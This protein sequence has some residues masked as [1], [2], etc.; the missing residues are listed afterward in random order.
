MTIIKGFTHPYPSRQLYPRGKIQC[1]LYYHPASVRFRP[2]PFPSKYSLMEIFQV[3]YLGVCSFG[4]HCIFFYYYSL[5]SLFG[6]YLNR[7]SILSQSFSLGLSLLFLK[8]THLLSLGCCLP[9]ALFFLFLFFL[10]S[11]R[12][13][14]NCYL[15]LSFSG[16][17]LSTFYATP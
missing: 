13:K 17:K 16:Y 15:L 11:A 7:S 4:S 8:W 1:H 6:V 12:W 3:I 10:N 14:P 9:D 2:I 5:L